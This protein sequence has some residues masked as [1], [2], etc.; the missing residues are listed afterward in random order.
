MTCK[1]D[2]RPLLSLYLLA[3]LDEKLKEYIALFLKENVTVEEMLRMM[4]KK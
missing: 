4:D 3:I 1:D 2:I